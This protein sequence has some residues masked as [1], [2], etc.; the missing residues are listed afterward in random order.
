MIG[1]HCGVSL[2]RVSDN[3][4]YFKKRCP[5]CGKTF[6]QRK[7]RSANSGDTRDPNCDQCCHAPGEHPSA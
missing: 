3:R 4:V 6:K 5:K 7:R 2:V 1:K